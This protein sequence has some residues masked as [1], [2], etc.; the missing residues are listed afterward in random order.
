[1]KKI[2]EKDIMNKAMEAT[3]NNER[4]LEH[5]T[6]VRY[7]LRTLDKAYN[8]NNKNRS[9]R[10]SR[11]SKGSNGKK[12]NKNKDDNNN[13]DNQKG[14]IKFEDGFALVRA[15][16]TGPNI[17][18]RFESKYEEKLQNIQKDLLMN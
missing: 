5:I 11:G 17:T 4:K 9:S 10:G 3:F 7:S 16:N 13:D 8:E 6:P 14:F 1:M 18:M 12:K 2:D 15:S